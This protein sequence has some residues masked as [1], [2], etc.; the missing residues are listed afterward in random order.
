M[1][2]SVDSP[3]GFFL[4]SGSKYSLRI[5]SLSEQGIRAHVVVF[6][7]FSSRPLWY[8]TPR[9]GG[10]LSML[11]GAMNF[12]VSPVIQELETLAALGFDYLELTMLPL[13]LGLAL[14]WIIYDMDG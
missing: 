8:A 4:I 7:L 10:P 3:G 11:Y 14:I 2:S 6:V 1:G 5:G 13:F 9:G 12:P